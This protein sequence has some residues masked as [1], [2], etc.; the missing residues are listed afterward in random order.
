[1]ALPMT[2]FLMIL[3]L[4]KGNSHLFE[5]LLLICSLIP[6]S[7]FDR[8]MRQMRTLPFSTNK[9]SLILFML[10]LANLA[11]ITLTLVLV[12]LIGVQ[13]V[14][15]GNSASLLLM[16]GTIS[17]C[18]SLSLRL[19]QKALPLILPLGIFL[20]VAYSEL[21]K[22]LSPIFFWILGLL[23]IGASFGLLRVWLQSSATYRPSGK[24]FAGI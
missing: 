2:F 21:M 22:S 10:P 17:I 1:M 16:A 4:F 13:R 24:S 7:G 6:N 19:G 11:T 9:L 23:L 14:F 20:V 12:H 5:F 15:G 3:G 18:N 8:S